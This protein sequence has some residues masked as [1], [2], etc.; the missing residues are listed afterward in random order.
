[1]TVELFEPYLLGNLELKNR[2]VMS[3]MCMYSAATDGTIIDWHLTHYE[4]RSVGQ[5]GMIIIEATAVL[6]EGRISEHDLGI[7]EDE[8][9]DGLQKIAGGIKRHGAKAAIQLGHAG[10]KANVREEIFA[11]SALAFSE[12][13]KRP[14]TMTKAKIFELV[15]AYKQAAL[16]ADQAGFDV[17]EIHAAHGYLLNQFLSPLTNQRTDEY[18]G[19]PENRYRLLG[20]VIDSVRSVW[21]KPLLVRISANDFAAGGM[22]PE[23]YVP[24]AKWMKAQAVDLIDV[25]SG[26][27]VPTQIN[28]FPGYQ[29]PY[30]DLIRKEAN[31]PT[32]AVGLISSG[33][34]AEEILGNDRADLI[35]LGRVLLRD[36]YWPYRAA[37]ELATELTAPKQYQRGW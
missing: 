8:Q 27:V 33:I 9:I 19:S 18:G 12:K 24:I 32:S 22:T 13:Y 16:R 3:P 20:E 34:Q 1:M 2:I 28:S 11:P 10:R 30:A 5:V 17:I 31:I 6:P 26:A 25:S 14:T 7:W 23:D 29:V 37:K 15:A 36:P 21:Q 35:M 4:S